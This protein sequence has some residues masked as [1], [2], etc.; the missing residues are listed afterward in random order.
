VSVE[1]LTLRAGFDRNHAEAC[2]IARAAPGLR[3]SRVMRSVMILAALATLPACFFTEG[4]ADHDYDPQPPDDD[5]DPPDPPTP[6]GINLG[7]DRKVA[8]G[9]AEHYTVPGLL[10]NLNDAVFESSHPTLLE[11]FLIDENEIG[12]ITHAP[13]TYTITAR[14][15]GF[16]QILD[17]L[18]VFALPVEE[19]VFD[20]EFLPDQVSAVTQFSA[21]AGA[22]VGVCATYF[23]PN[24]DRIPG[25]G[26]FTTTGGLGVINDDAPGMDNIRSTCL[27]LAAGE[28]GPAEL[29]ASVENGISRTLT[30]DVQASP[31]TATLKVFVLREDGFVEGIPAQGEFTVVSV[32]GRTASGEF[33]AGTYGDWEVDGTIV[34]SHASGVFFQAGASGTEMTIVATIGALTRTTS[35]TVK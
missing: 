24:R 35:F 18:T 34:N 31:A 27:D 22:Q 3:D 5:D 2:R 25:H 1:G 9:T 21:M 32:E 13:G 20:Q 8:A 14:R 11:V 10:A 19:I 26:Q 6:K 7:D 29:I 28:P 33:L 12:F 17:T 4:Y 30:I 23:G 15:E 16:P